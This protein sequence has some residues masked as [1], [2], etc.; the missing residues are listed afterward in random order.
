MTLLELL[1]IV[2]V[3]LALGAWAVGAWANRANRTDDSAH[4]DH[5][6]RKRTE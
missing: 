3:A 1:M 6:E 4:R 5:H 2:F